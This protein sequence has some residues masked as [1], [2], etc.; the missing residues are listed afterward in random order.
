MTI[1][2]IVIPVYNSAPIV[3]RTLDRVVAACEA[4]GESFEVIA[5]DDAS[6]DGSRH[7]LEEAARRHRAIRVIGLDANAGQHAALLVGLRASTGDI[8][9]CMDD[10]MQHI[11]EAIPRL[12]E[13]LRAGHDAVFAR[14]AHSSHAWWRQG[15][16]LLM[17]AIDRGVFGA[18]SELVVSSFRAMR[19]DVVDRVCAYRG[20]SPY[21]RGQ[22]LR[23]SRTPANVDVEHAGRAG[24][25]SYTPIALMGVTV[26]VL[27]EWS[28]I[29]AWCC[30]AAGMAFLA[31]AAGWHRLVEPAIGGLAM[32][33]SLHGSA[34][35]GLGAAG[36]AGRRRQERRAAAL[37]APGDRAQSHR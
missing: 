12:V 31:A 18:P 32:P 7:V 20:T 11:P 33:L 16:S 22:I 19:R 13:R 34:L 1:I 9:V 15:G 3:G 36:L 8:V 10:D 14:F 6:R 30:L 37:H 24:A 23:A 21:V 35:V 27:L 26:R 28:A 29:P 17:R 25:S 2:S 5:V 4:M